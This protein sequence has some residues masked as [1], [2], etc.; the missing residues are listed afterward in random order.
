MVI[1]YPRIHFI[2]AFFFFLLPYLKMNNKKA[3]P[4]RTIIYFFESVHG[5]VYSL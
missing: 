5:L 3:L 1:K 2:L 4:R